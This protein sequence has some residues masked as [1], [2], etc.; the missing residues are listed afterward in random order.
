M[1]L[2]KPALQVA[3][4]H[5]LRWRPCVCEQLCS[6]RPTAAFSSGALLALLAATL[7]VGWLELCVQ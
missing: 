7:G 4:E 5:D 3:R 1:P 2:Q 6:W